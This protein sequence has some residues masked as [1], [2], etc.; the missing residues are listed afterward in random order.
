MRV[1]VRENLDR[2][3]GK[4]RKYLRLMILALSLLLISLG[5]R[6][7]FLAKEQRPRHRPRAVLVA[8]LKIQLPEL[9]ECAGQ[10]VFVLCPEAVHLILPGSTWSSDDYRATPFPV[11]SGIET[12]PS[13]A[14]PPGIMSV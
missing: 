5:M 9:L 6:N 8:A 7:M 11:T 3:Q 12:P 2:K 1:F 13:R 4:Q 10:P 14:P